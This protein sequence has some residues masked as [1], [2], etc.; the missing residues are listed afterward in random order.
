[1]TVKVYGNDIVCC[2]PKGL[3]CKSRYY[4]WMCIFKFC[5]FVL[6][7]L[8]VMLFWNYHLENRYIYIYML[9]QL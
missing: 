4:L 2:S 7:L 3:S 8:N 9:K 1:M 6:F 5:C